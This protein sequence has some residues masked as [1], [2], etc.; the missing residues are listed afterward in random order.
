[1]KKELIN[2]LD[3]LAEDLQINKISFREALVCLKLTIQNYEKP[4]KRS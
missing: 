4:I 2:D 3:K 1:M